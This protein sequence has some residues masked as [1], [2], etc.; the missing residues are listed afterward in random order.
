[1]VYVLI[2]FPFV[3]NMKIMEHL[4]EFIK[5]HWLLWLAF[6]VL[7]GLIAFEETRKSVRGI[8]RLAPDEVVNLMNHHEAIV[9]DLRE[10]TSFIHSHILGSVNLHLTSAD[11]LAIKIEPYKNKGIILLGK[12]D[13]STLS[14]GTKLKKLGITK[15]YLLKG[16]VVAWKN[17]GLPLT[18]K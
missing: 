2:Q 5:N 14:F 17:A 15:I 18:K 1:M 4:L 16:G 10:H 8:R 11:D 13:F 3:K 12:D 6:F 9:L 7:L